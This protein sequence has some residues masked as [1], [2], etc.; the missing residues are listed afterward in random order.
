MDRSSILAD[1]PGLVNARIPQDVYVFFDD[2]LGTCFA[3]DGTAEQSVWLKT[4]IATQAVGQCTILD[5]TDDAEDEAGGILKVTTGATADEG[6]NL[7]VNGEAFHLADGYPLY[8]EA[9]VNVADVS[10]L[11][12]F[13]GLATT[14]GEIIT[15]SKTTEINR[16]G[17]ELEAG[18]ISALSSTTTLEKR[19]NTNITE[20]D[21]DWIRIAFLW[22]GDNKVTFYVDTN[23]NGEFTLKAVLHPDTTAD[24]VQ[25]A[26]MFTPT[27]EAITGTTAT[28]E[29]MY[30]DYIYCAQQRYH[31]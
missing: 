6:D 3:D 27:I 9:R 14:D 20:T 8:F 18:V 1:F 23:D 24:Y 22:D 13:I 30:V 31:E 19:V 15:G 26:I 11:D 7:Q 17:F 2:F 4:E 29:F 21:D 12:F 16:I 28:A 10:N 25:Q 5:G